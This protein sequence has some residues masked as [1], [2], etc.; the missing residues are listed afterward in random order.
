MTSDLI[1]KALG[2]ATR[3]SL[4]ERLAR[5]GEFSVHALTASAGVSQPM[6]SRHLAQLKRAGLVTSRRAGRETY[7]SARTK[8]IGPVVEWMALY[9]AL[10]SQRFIALEKLAD[11]QG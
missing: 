5:D 7:Y 1:F 11:R 3:R 10:W 6:V 4:F 2:D 8:G 9:G